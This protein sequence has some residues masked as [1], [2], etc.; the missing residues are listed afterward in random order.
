MSYLDLDRRNKDFWYEI[1]TNYFKTNNKYNKKGGIVFLGDSITDNFSV[2]EMFPDFTV[3][4]RGI[5]GDHT[6]GVYDRLQSS[7]FDLEPEK[8][9]LLV[10]TN[11]LSFFNQDDEKMIADRIILIINKIKAVLPNTKIYLQ[12]IYPVNNIMKNSIAGFRNNERI[13]KVNQYL[14]EIN[15]VIFIDIYSKLL[16]D[17]TLNEL[18]T[19]DGLHMNNVG[20]EVIAKELRKYLE[21]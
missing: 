3:Y 7:V 14:K 18:Y 12:S 20:Y 5:N 21:R 17:N 10:G 2:Y 9:F 4:N 19:Y 1:K 16:S 15:D 6:Y 13:E 11:D 8:V